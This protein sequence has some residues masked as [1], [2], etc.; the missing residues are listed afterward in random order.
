MAFPDFPFNDDLPSFV[1][2][3]D[4]CQYLANFTDHFHLRE[5]IKVGTPMY[6]LTAL[7]VEEKQS[8]HIV[9]D[10]V[11]YTVNVAQ[12]GSMRDLIYDICENLT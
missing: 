12:V 11:K 7:A 2:H 8:C 9:Y 1:K 5:H 3:T 10:C 4:V 6:Q